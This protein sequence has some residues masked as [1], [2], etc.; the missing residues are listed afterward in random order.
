MKTIISNIVVGLLSTV[1]A[2]FLFTQ[3]YQPLPVVPQAEEIPAQLV[4]HEEDK[5]ILN[6]KPQYKS[7]LSLPDFREVSKK[8]TECVVNIT[9]YSATGYRVASGSG[10]IISSDGYIVT[11]NHVVE[12]GSRLEVALSDKRQLEAEVLGTDPST[13]LALIRVKARGLQTV[14][15][16]NSD[17]VD[18]GEWV[19]AVGNPFNLTSTVTA[20]IVSAKA[21]NIRILESNYS[22][23]SF[24]Q[25]DA[26]VNPGNSGGAL[27]NT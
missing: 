21:R 1:L 13:D 25:T 10:V 2:F 15:F 23:E 12:D 19:L 20:G 9:V 14:E 5:P 24:I 18:I 22:I 11:N 17:L 16:G 8:A 26:V 27:V 6:A 7:I 3:Y 4:K